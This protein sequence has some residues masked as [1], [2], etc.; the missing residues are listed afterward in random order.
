MLLTH[1]T[2]V[3]LLA[4]LLAFA[5]DS[6]AQ[7]MKGEDVIAKHLESIGTTQARAAIKNQ[8]AI[9]T[10]TVKFVS[11]QNSPLGGRV[12]LASTNEKSFLGMNLNSAEY[13]SEKFI[14]DGKKTNVGFIKSGSRSVL[15]NFV[16]TNKFVLVEGLLGGAISRSWSLLDYTNKKVRFSFGGTKKIN[17]KDAFVVDYLSKGINDVN[18]TLY[19]DKETFRHIRTEYKR[20]TSSRI[21]FTPDQSIKLN[22]SQ[23]KI[24]E[25]FSDFRTENNLTLPHGYSLLY[26]VTGQTGTTEIEWAFDLNQFAFNQNLDAKTFDGEGN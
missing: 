6:F 14:Y 13:P 22:E 25:N 18:T 23:L 20:V 16:Q 8:I 9:G 19:F 1:L 12:V 21:G 2:K 4:F 10:V 3:L 15:G 26:S 5:V 17:G 24:V 7:K 11:P